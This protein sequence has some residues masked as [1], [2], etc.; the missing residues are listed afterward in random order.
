MRANDIKN[1][2]PGFTLQHSEAMTGNVMCWLENQG[3]VFSVDNPLYQPVRFAKD[4][5][6]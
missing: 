3:Q 5:Q 2:E 4:G 6:I 1:L